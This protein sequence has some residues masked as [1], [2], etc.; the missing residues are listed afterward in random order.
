MLASSKKFICKHFRLLFLPDKENSV[1]DKSKVSGQRAYV[2][3]LNDA[4][5]QFITVD[6]IDGGGIWLRDEAFSVGLFNSTPDKGRPIL[7]EDKAP[8]TFLPHHRVEWMMFAMKD[9]R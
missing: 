1:I 5:P 4:A 3:L 6:Q 7:L 9:L 2:K 8:L